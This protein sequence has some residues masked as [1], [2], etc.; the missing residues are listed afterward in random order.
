MS[1]T[2]ASH[3]YDISGQLA[4]LAAARP[5]SGAA[6]PLLKK[7]LF[8]YQGHTSEGY[9][10]D[11]SPVTP[12]LLAS[13]DNDGDIRIWNPRLAAGAAP[14]ARR[15]RQRQREQRGRWGLGHLGLI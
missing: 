6:A 11:W 14:G 9:A 13:G 12:G 4:R 1:D 7:P 15:R 5:P 2:S 10:L 8:T 3:V